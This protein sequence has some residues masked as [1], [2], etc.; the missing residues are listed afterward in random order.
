MSV[1]IEL[2]REHAHFTNLDIVTGKLIVNL[3]SETSIAGIQVKLEGE[4]RT[5]LSEESDKK[6]TEGEVHKV[7]L[8]RDDPW[9]YNTIVGWDSMKRD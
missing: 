2:G 9:L 7:R 8:I 1:I 6:R 3:P 4:S 5:R